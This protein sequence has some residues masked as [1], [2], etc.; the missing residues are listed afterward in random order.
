MKL[1]ALVTGLVA[2]LLVAGQAAAV[3]VVDAGVTAQIADTQTDITTIGGLIISLS[4]L[5]MGVRWVK[6]TFF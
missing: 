3:S 4:A 5:A 6:A 2:S 1:F